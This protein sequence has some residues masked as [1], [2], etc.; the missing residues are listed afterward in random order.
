[1]GE[2]RLETKSD[3]TVSEISFVSIYQ[4]K[5]LL[6]IDKN[7][8]FPVSI[9]KY[10]TITANYTLGLKNVLNSDFSFH[11]ASLNVKHNIP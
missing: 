9:K 8:R 4:P 6:I 11:K 5:A 2:Q 10:P 7:N 3:I 1:L